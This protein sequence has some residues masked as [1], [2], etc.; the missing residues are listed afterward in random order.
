[1]LYK[2]WKR[3]CLQAVEDAGLDAIISPAFACPAMLL[4]HNCQASGITIMKIIS[5]DELK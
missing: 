1:M 3:N 5:L 2:T 4:K